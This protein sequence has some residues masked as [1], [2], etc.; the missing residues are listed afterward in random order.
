MCAAT[1]TVP[2]PFNFAEKNLPVAPTASMIRC[3]HVH[4]KSCIVSATVTW[5]KCKL[6]VYS[7]DVGC[8]LSCRREHAKLF[9]MQR[10]TVHDL[11][12]RLHSL[13]QKNWWKKMPNNNC[14][15]NQKPM[16]IKCK[17]YTPPKTAQLTPTMAGRD[18]TC[19]WIC[20]ATQFLIFC[21]C[22]EI[23]FN[24]NAQTEDYMLY[25]CIN[26]TFPKKMQ[27]MKICNILGREK[28]ENYDTCIPTPCSDQPS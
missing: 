19:T 13:R 1:T 17:K 18:V 6:R 5:K 28:K 2:F 26:A 16:A 11:G 24:Q 20:R 21:V 9:V 12:N 7:F 10:N 25:F 8:T 15:E 3:P 14:S 4:C 23:L 22:V 27:K